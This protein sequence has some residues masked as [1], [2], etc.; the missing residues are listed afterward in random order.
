MVKTKILVFAVTSRRA[1]EHQIAIEQTRNKLPLHVESEGVCIQMPPWDI[2]DYSRFMVEELAANVPAHFDFVLT[3]NWDGYAI[4]SERWTD[5]FLSFDYIGA[6]WSK[7]FSK[8]GQRVGN[9][10]FSLRSRAWINRASRLKNPQGLPEDTFQCSDNI[11]FFKEK[12]LK[13]APL[14]LAMRFSAEARIGEYKNWKLS[15]SFGFHSWMM[16]GAEKYRLTYAVTFKE[17]LQA[18]KRKLLAETVKHF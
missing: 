10:G 16:P 12:G 1:I 13:V 15:D 7:F 17:K 2:K 8:N 9:G 6:P 14:D 4:N 18:W 11:T 3:V 5:D